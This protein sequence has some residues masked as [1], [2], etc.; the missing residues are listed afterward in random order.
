MSLQKPVAKKVTGTIMP[1]DPYQRRGNPM[2]SFSCIACLL[3]LI[4]FGDM[5][6]S[7]GSGG[8]T[9]GPGARKPA[10]RFNTAPPRHEPADYQAP[11]V[12]V[13]SVD[14]QTIRLLL[15]KADGTPI[16]TEFAE[17]KTFV[18]AGGKLSTIYLWPAG[19][20]LLSGKGDFIPEPGMRVD[21]KLHLPGR[22]TIRK[23]FYPLKKN[24]GNIR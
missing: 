4:T 20:N 11:P 6:F 8:D 10:I 24:D 12:M 19:D 23:D 5:A 2:R 13:L 22:E 9:T 21:V 16:N 7:H 15:S 1:T 3:A 14:G 17:A 18:N